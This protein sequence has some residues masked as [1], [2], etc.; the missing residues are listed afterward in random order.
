MAP[1]IIGL[2]NFCQGFEHSGG[3][4]LAPDRQGFLKRIS[5]I[6]LFSFPTGRMALS[7]SVSISGVWV[8]LSSTLQREMSGTKKIFSVVYCLYLPP[9]TFLQ[10]LGYC[11]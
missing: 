7:I 8:A 4:H 5:F 10:S 2:Q 11:A 3:A 6:Y 9:N 1:A